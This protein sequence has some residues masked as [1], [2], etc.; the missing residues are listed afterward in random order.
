[1]KKARVI[2]GLSVQSFLYEFEGESGSLTKALE[3]YNEDLKRAY[4]AKSPEQAK[5]ILDQSRQNLEANGLNK[6][7]DFVQKK[8]D[9]G[10]K[11]KF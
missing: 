3:R 9:S 5:Q 6:F 10:V 7:L 4:Y 1:M 2:D 8:V 11:V